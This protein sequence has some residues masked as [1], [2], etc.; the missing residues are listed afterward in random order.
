MVENRPY[1]QLKIPTLRLIMDG[2]VSTSRELA[3]ALDLELTNSC[4][5]LL[6]LR[7]WGLLRRRRVKIPGKKTTHYTYEITDRGEARL[8]WLLAHPRRS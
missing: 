6:R 3:E 5:V 1:N 7:R 2:Q 4:D 8:S